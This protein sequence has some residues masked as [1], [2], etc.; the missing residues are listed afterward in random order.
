MQER[1]R[2]PPPRCF[3]R[4]AAVSLVSTP[5]A[6]FSAALP[7]WRIYAFFKRRRAVSLS[8]RLPAAARP[9]AIGFPGRE[10][11]P[12][13][14]V[15]PNSRLFHSLMCKLWAKKRANLDAESL[16][17]QPTLHQAVP[18]AVS[19]IAFSCQGCCARW[20]FCAGLCHQH[21]PVGPDTDLDHAPTAGMQP[22]S[23]A[24]PAPAALPS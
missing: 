23:S 17:S 22:H 20:I 14:R 4:T 16:L 3:A 6:P 8:L 7:A 19:N 11:R 18:T 9:H 21:L 12:G 15:C 5:T 10:S 2:E 24:T 13:S 1:A